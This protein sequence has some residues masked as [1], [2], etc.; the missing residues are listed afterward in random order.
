MSIVVTANNKDR[1]SAQ[2]FT[3]E[4]KSNKID[5][6]TNSAPKNQMTPRL[7]CPHGVSAPWGSAHGNERDSLMTGA[8]PSPFTTAI[9]AAQETI[10]NWVRIMGI[11]SLEKYLFRVFFVFSEFVYDLEKYP[12]T[13]KNIGI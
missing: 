8:H 3:L 4:R 7:N 5:L 11:Q 2:L 10:S 13:I 6:A 9:T 1:G 12:A